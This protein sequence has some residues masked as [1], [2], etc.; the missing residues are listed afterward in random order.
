MI[1]Y[2]INHLRKIGNDEVYSFSVTRSYLNIIDEYY[3]DESLIYYSSGRNSRDGSETVVS[4][5]CDG[6]G[7]DDDYAARN[8][9][10][11]G[12]DNN[13]NRSKNRIF[14]WN[15]IYPPSPINE[16]DCYSSKTFRIWNLNKRWNS[17][18]NGDDEYNN[19]SNNNNDNDNNN[20]NNNEMNGVMKS[21][22]VWL[23]GERMYVSPQNL[24][25]EV[26]F[27]NSSNSF[28]EFSSSLDLRDEWITP[29]DTD[30]EVEEALINGSETVVSS[31][32]DGNGSDDDYAARNGG[33]YGDDNNNNRSKNR[34]F[35]WNGIYPPSPINENDCYSSKTFRIWN[36]NKRWNSI[37][38][39]DDEYNNDS[40]NNNDNDNNNTNNNEMFIYY[41]PFL[42][43]PCYNDSLYS[44]IL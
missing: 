23:K 16:N 1:Y 36:L 24:E 28:S 21:R 44:N 26:D 29:T 19:D 9:G 12:D 40:N 42:C 8:G 4:S 14:G 5:S 34:I 10:G 33:G 38:N 31:S 20:T 13:N 32:C 2:W 43:V 18:N 6:N 39:G 35:G 25:S 7:S 15:G 11:Y 41:I 30:A 3:N 22:S 27:V 17:I 37:N